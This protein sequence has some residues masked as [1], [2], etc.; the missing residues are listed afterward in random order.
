MFNEAS[1][2]Q[3]I[4]DTLVSQGWEYI[5]AENL[6]RKYTDVMVEPMV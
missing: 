1:I 4:I 6:P 5:S 2:E 3:M